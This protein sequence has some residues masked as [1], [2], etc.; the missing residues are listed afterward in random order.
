[1]VSASE[2]F[3]SNPIST[4]GTVISIADQLVN[5]ISSDDYSSEALQSLGD[6]SIHLDYPE[7]HEEGDNFGL[8]PTTTMTLDRCEDRKDEEKGYIAMV[9][10]VLT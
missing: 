5:F 4:T 9:N 10:Y 6:D 8:E 2:K 1:M 7:D 3:D